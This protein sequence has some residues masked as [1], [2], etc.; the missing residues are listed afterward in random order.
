MRNPEDDT[1]LV[2]ETDADRRRGILSDNA[3]SLDSVYGLARDRPVTIAEQ[4]VLDELQGTSKKSPYSIT[5]TT[6]HQITTILQSGLFDLEDRFGEFDQ[7]GDPLKALNE[8][9]DWS[10]CG[11]ILAKGSQK[12]KKSNAGRQGF[13]PL[14]MFKALILQYL[15][16]L[17]DGQFEFQIRDHFTFLCFL[18]LTP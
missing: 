2:E 1:S 11:P 12:E 5:P 6:K 8:V 13:D 18:G 15:Y 14:L 10:A 3:L 17:C 16:N 9:V 7:L 4:R